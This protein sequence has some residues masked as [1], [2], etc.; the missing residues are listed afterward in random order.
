MLSLPCL[1]EFAPAGAKEFQFIFAAR[2]CRVAKIPITERGVLSL[3]STAFEAEG[4]ARSA[5]SL[6]IGRLSLSILNE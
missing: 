5:I 4:S 2:L 3:K 1:A 6:R